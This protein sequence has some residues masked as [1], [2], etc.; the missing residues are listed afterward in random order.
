[1]SRLLTAAA[2]RSRRTGTIA[3]GECMPPGATHASAADGDRQEDAT[4]G[5]NQRSLSCAEG[6]WRISLF[7][8]STHPPAIFSAQSQLWAPLMALA[9]LGFGMGVDGR[10]A[11]LRVASGLITRLAPSRPRVYSSL[12]ALL[13][14]PCSLASLEACWAQQASFWPSSRPWRRRGRFSRATGPAT[15]AQAQAQAQSMTPWK[16][17]TMTTACSRWMQQ[18]MFWRRSSL[19]S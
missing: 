19:S 3:T 4:A 17:M 2:S 16:R 8:G 7:E 15:Q 14:A 13:S 9:I 1:M 5:P 12:Q 10:W 18:R 6:W 11:V